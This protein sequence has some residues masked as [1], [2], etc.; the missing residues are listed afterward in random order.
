[1][2]NKLLIFFMLFGSF[3]VGQT[4]YNTA[5]AQTVACPSGPGP[6][7]AGEAAQCSPDTS[8]APGTGE[9]E[10]SVRNGANLN[11]RSTQGSTQTAPVPAETPVPSTRVIGPITTRSEFEMFAE[12]AAGRT[13]HVYGRQLFDEG[14]TTFAPMDR[15]PVPADYVL[16]PGDQLLIRVWGKIDLDDGVTVDRN[17]Q[18]FIPKVGSFR[19]A[20]LRYEQI[21]SFLRAAIGNLY[22]GFE[23]NV[24]MGKLR[25][26]QIFV[27][28]SARQPG[29]YTV[30]SLSTLVNALFAS[31]GP[32]ATGSMRHIQL[33]RDNRVLVDFDIYD[34][35]RRGD[36]SRDIQLLPGDVIYI[37]PVGPQVA[38]MGSINEPGIY[39]L[40]GETTIAAAL[41][42]A[43]GLT[44][45]A[46]VDRVLLERIENHRRRRVDDFPL[47]A[48]ELQ[49]ALN[50]GDLLRIFPITPQFESTVMLRGNVAQ[51]GRF[52]W[53]EGMRVADLIPSRDSL[54]TR[55]Y[56]YEESHLTESAPVGSNWSDEN[57]VR[58]NP[59]GAGVPN[60]HYGTAGNPLGVSAP[61]REYDAAG[62]PIDAGAPNQEY[63]TDG[64][65][66]GGSR[67]NQ[68]NSSPVHIPIDMMT[69]LVQNTAEI[70]WDYASIQRLDEKDLSTRLIAFN[71]GN[72]INNPASPDNQFLKPGDVVTIFS[73]S[74]LPLPMDKHAT[75]VR[76]SGEINAPGVYRV[77]PGDTLRNVVER[78]GGLTPH[79]YL[80]ASQLTRVSTREA[81]E[82][83]LKVSSAEMQREITSRYAAASSVSTNNA[84]EQQ[85]SLSAQQAAIA[86]LAGVKP[87]GRIVLDMKPGASTVADIPNFPLEDGDSFYIPPKLSTVQVA[88]AVYNE[89][90]FRYQ[91]GKHLSAYV[92]DA[93]GPT[94]QGDAKRIFLVRADGTVISRQ[95]HGQFW[96]SD[97]ESTVLLPGDAI[98]V[99]TK[100][101][102]PSNFMQQ[103]PY[104][105][106]MLSQT[107]MTGAVLGTSY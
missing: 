44:N 68:Q 7:S 97:F 2:T 39:E 43:G 19:V 98:I 48:L 37:P 83:Q 18:V 24:T 77:E 81:E 65:L 78:A 30:S 28:G 29:T 101:K 93:G 38:L 99:P 25:S 17:G 90:A 33:R 73:R 3:C 35:L 9:N 86:Q 62:N 40:R 76:V 32:S 72:A 91:P 94:R 67:L 103:L 8:Q 74:D 79:S 102:S 95:S 11:S 36:K 66:P 88:G 75:F 10:N 21:E 51:P 55:S 96:H 105:T 46:A 13:L 87:T 56:W 23:L 84:T 22:K 71:L 64:N 47:D 54:I 4:D 50:D 82:E 80:Y 85:T 31:G 70:N 92:N 49:H 26:I 107:A 12:D 27:L 53:H 57:G 14:P 69:E 42:D 58:R 41:T 60:Q 45:L 104:W 16:G 1:M 63:G 59:R 52:P 34:L 5:L 100:L 20:G 61:N 6:V 106:Q 89:N 15:V